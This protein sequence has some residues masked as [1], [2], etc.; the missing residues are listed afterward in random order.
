[1]NTIIQQ[2]DRID[3]LAKKGT[4]IEFFSA[5][6][7]MDV[8]RMLS[9]CHP[10]GTISFVPLGSDYAGKINEI[11]KAVWSALMDSFPNLDNTVKSQQYD[12]TTDEVTC[13]VVIFGKQEKEFAGLAPKGN[14]FD[15]EHIFIFR[16]NEEGKISDLNIQWNHESFVNQLSQ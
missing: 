6:Q 8:D 2:Q 1:M 12:E 16:F 10:D 9:L 4:C 5:Y 3:V 11:G 14:S 7:D 13:K 15:S